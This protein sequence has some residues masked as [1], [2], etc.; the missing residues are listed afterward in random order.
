MRSLKKRGPHVLDDLMTS[1]FP[2]TITITIIPKL[3]SLLSQERLKLGTSNLAGIFIGSIR[4]QAHEKNWRKWSGGV[5]RDGPNF[6]EYPLLSHER[7]K[8]R[9]L[10][11]AGIFIGSIRAKAP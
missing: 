11:L 9:T 7:V 8:L 3:Q 4:L 10:N 5:S 1:Y 2:Y 6:F